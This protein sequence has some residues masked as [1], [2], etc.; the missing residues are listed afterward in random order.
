[1]FAIEP[2]IHHNEE[3]VYGR[4]VLM[5]YPAVDVLL[6]AVLA[7]FFVTPAWRTAAYALLVPAV[8]FLIWADE[9]YVTNIDGYAGGQWSDALWLISYLL[10]AVTALTPSMRTLGETVPVSLTP[11]LSIGRLLLLS[12]ALLSAPVALVIQA[13]GSGTNTEYLIGAA[14]IAL[15]ALVLM[16]I[17]GLVRTELAK[18]TKEL[19]TPEELEKVKNKIS[20][21][22]MFAEM[23]VLNVAMNLCFAEL[24]GDANLANQ[25]LEQYQRVTAEMIR[26]RSAHIFRKENSST[27]YYLSEKK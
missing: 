2:Y 15:S 1:V 22:L 19:V 24:M 21:N 11:R 13:P 8:G 16:R 3:S 27:L 5:A 14:S 12:L 26:D 4:V 17:I 6:I 20:S 7:R 10:F 18:M 25:E 23:N 9:I